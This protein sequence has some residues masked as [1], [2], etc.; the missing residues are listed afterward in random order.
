[1]VEWACA[2]CTFLNQEHLQACA[3]CGTA[4]P[5]APGDAVRQFND[6]ALARAIKASEAAPSSGMNHTAVQRPPAVGIGQQPSRP[7][8]QAATPAFGQTQPPPAPAP[9]PAPE[10][11][12][13]PEP[14]MELD[15]TALAGLTE[16]EQLAQVLALTEAA[17]RQAWEIKNRGIKVRVSGIFEYSIVVFT[18]LTAEAE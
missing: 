7:F 14:L 2:T 6:D 13:E 18:A 10:P 1:M 4:R 17:D 11:A 16:A 12:P 3:M 9:A 15:T 8:G 5:E